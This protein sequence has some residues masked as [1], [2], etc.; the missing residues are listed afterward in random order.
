M[1][2]KTSL[3]ILQHL[4]SELLKITVANGYV[5]TIQSVDREYQ[6]RQYDT[7]PFF[8]I[9]DID[10]KYVRRIAKDLYKKILIVQ[11]VGF[12]YDDSRSVT[13]ATSAQ[14]GTKLQ[15]LKDDLAKCLQADTYF[16]SSDIE[17][18]ILEMVT[19]SSYVPPQASFVCHLSIIHYEG[20]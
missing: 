15:Q 19:D 18:A 9:N 11:I 12:I 20:Q 4:E 8:F 5:N 7:Y 17:M 2:V 14:L 10:D 1:A 3:E 6:E 16:N 13:G